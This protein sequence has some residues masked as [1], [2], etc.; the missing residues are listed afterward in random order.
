MRRLSLAKITKPTIRGMVPRPRLFKLLDRGRRVP[1]IWVSGPAGSGKTTLVASYLEA[2][3]LP[4]LWYQVDEGDADIATFFYYL[5][6]AARKAAPRSRRPMPLLTPEYAF[7]IPTFTKRYFEELSLRLGAPFVL[8]FDNYQIVPPDSPF[9][10]IIQSGLSR[11]PQGIRTVI[12]SRTDPPPAF[13]RMQANGTM[14]GIG[15]NELRLSADESRGIVRSSG[16]QRLPGDVIRRIHE[17]TQGWAAGLTL[18]TASMRRS[19]MDPAVMESLPADGVFD[20]FANELFDKADPVTQHFLLKSSLLPKITVSAARMLTG[21]RQAD[22]ILSDLHRN[23]FFTEMRRDPGL[24]YQYHPLFRAFLLSRGESTYSAIELSRTRSTAARLLEQSGQIED[25]AELLRASHDV[26]AL[27]GLIRRNAAALVAQGRFK[28]L[29][30]WLRSLPE[31]TLQNDPWLLYWLG[32]CLLP[33]SPPESRVFLEKAFH[34]FGGQVDPAGELLAWS[35]IVDTYLYEWNDFTPLDRWILWLDRRVRDKK[36]LLPVEIERRVAISMFAALVIRQPHHPRAQHWLERA[37]LLTDHHED[38]SLTLQARSYGAIYFAWI[39]DGANSQRMIHE[40]DALAHA[41]QAAPLVQ[42]TRKWTS[43]AGALWL[44]MVPDEAVK[45]AADSLA[46]AGTT[47]VHV[48]DH[49]LCA[50]GFFGSICA[51]AGIHRGHGTDPRA[52]PQTRLQSLPL[53]DRLAAPARGRSCR[54]VDPCGIRAQYRGRDRLHVSAHSLPD[55]D[56]A[57]AH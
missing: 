43:A 36:S 25:A 44:R 28:T 40:L 7:G 10:E 48:W 1:A 55:P 26:A 13:A 22:R 34:L 50:V 45:M 18:V 54:C 52:E 57:S 24:S 20:Y 49:M 9:H 17:K 8:V 56:S 11:L 39:G 47:G 53:P 5:G 23:N 3:K 19:A 15:P 6:L 35:G 33:V 4:C 30:L 29:E 14:Q 32:A 46:F 2:R 41:S 16:E 51:G 31:K 21:I 12:I 27:A 37:L 38:I 42:L